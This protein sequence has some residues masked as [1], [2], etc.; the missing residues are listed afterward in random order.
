M[1]KLI[2][3][4]A[5]TSISVGATAAIPDPIDTSDVVLPEVSLDTLVANFGDHATKE[6]DSYMTNLAKEYPVNTF[7]IN[8]VP[9]NKE[10][11]FVI[12]E[13][14]DTLY[15]HAILDVTKS[16][17]IT[18]PEYDEYGMVQVI[19]ENGYT[20][21]TV[22]PGESKTLTHD[23]LSSGNHV[24][25]NTRVGAKNY[26]G[27][28]LKIANDYQDA[29]KITSETSNPYQPKNYDQKVLIA[30]RNA[31]ST[32]RTQVPAPFNMFGTKD[33]V[34]PRSYLIASAAGW[35]GLPAKDAAYVPMVVGNTGDPQCSSLTVN[36]PPLQ[37]DRHAFFSMT[38]YNKDGWIVDDNY[39]LSNKHM[40]PNSDGTYTFRFNCEGADN[41]LTV[42]EGW[43]PIFRMYLPESREAIIDYVTNDYLKKS[44]LIKG[45]A[46]Q[47]LSLI[48]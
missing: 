48:K 7:K 18:M 10:N 15:Q 19:D 17:T 14:E 32:L 24:F 34:E 26:H 3:A 31:L 20:I 5:I 16:A 23:M 38:V 8:R 45:S 13:N 33:M 22:Y 39:A 46:P 27:S 9:S 42:Q 2:L 40:K 6:T 4:I 37:Y 25:L 47:D 21:A 43:N 35:A 1:K 41:N 28:D 11:Q 44:K 30:E 36:K 12:R 29:I